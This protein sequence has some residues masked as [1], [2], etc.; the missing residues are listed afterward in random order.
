M[1]GPIAGKIMRLN[2][3]LEKNILKV[4]YIASAINTCCLKVKLFPEIQG[5]D[6]LVY[7]SV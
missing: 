2:F 5:T 6:L 7:D 1:G 4:M 3:S